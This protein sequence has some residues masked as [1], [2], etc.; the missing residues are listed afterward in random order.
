MA[1]VTKR[2]LSNRLSLQLEIT[3]REALVFVE[4][5]MESI[6]S[7]LAAG[8]TVTLRTFGTF[9]VRTARAK[10]GRNPA[11]PEAAVPIPA[12]RVVR[13][14]PGHELKERVMALPVE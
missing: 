7:A 4:A 1:T 11:Q 13:F 3:Q 6:G 9:E 8:D 10:V 12:R 14:R 5:M 2:E